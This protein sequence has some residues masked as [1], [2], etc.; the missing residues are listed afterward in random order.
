MSSFKES[1]AKKAQ[2]CKNLQ[3]EARQSG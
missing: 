1:A 3:W 2:L